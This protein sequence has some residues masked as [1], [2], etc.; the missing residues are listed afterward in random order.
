MYEELVWWLDICCLG[1]IRHGFSHGQAVI[2][3]CMLPRYQT[4]DKIFAST[5]TFYLR[6][7]QRVLNSPCKVRNATQEYSENQSKKTN[8]FPDPKCDEDI[9]VTNRYQGCCPAVSHYEMMVEKRRGKN[10][11]KKINKR[12][13]Q[14]SPAFNLGQSEHSILIFL[15]PISLRPIEPTSITPLPYGRIIDCTGGMYRRPEL[16]GPLVCCCH[17]IGSIARTGLFPWRYYNANAMA[18]WC[19]ATLVD[20][21][22]DRRVQRAGSRA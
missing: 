9:Y 13:M 19:R 4:P 18:N 3:C 8:S 1:I 11:K 2:V 20:P 22:A 7:N 10:K 15:F 16:Q 5:P 14:M 6:P 21:P 17:Q 12:H